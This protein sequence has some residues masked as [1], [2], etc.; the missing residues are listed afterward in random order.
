MN[1]L[2]DTHTFLWFING[3]SELSQSSKVIIEDPDNLKYISIATFWEIAIKININKL[4]IEMPFQELEWHV[5]KNDFHLLPITF[6]HTNQLITLPIFHRDPFDR[7]IIAQ[8]ICDSLIV[9]T[10]DNNFKHYKLPIIW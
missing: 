3:D 4:K 7:I 2:L 6:L 9:L 5:S 8:A 10:R 1:Y